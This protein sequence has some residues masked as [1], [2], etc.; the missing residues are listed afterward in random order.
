[1]NDFRALLLTETD[2]K[3]AAAIETLSEDRLPEGDVLID[4]SHSSLNYKDGMIINGLG[5][6]VRKYP[7]VPGVDFTGTVAKSEHPDFKPGDKV[8]LTGWRVGEIHWGGFAEK[9]RVKGDWLVPLPEGLS[10]QRAMAIGTAGLTAMLAVLALEEH[11]L[12]PGEAPVLV[13]GAA[14]GLGSVAV[15]VLAKLGYPVAAVTGRAEQEGY[16]RELGAT[17]IVSRETMATPSGKPLDPERWAGA[18]DAVG[19]A[20]LGNLVGQLRYGASVACC[21]NAGG[22]A[23]NSNVLPL[24][25][26]GVN[27]LGINSVMCPI[28]RR[29][30]AWER[31]SQDLPMAHLDALTQVVGLEDLPEMANKILK[32]EVRG[33]AVIDVRK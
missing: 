28:A 9:A 5:R 15:A 1:M 6:L 11:G 12:T 19:G 7:H 29:K 22:I 23:F 21:G 13:T 10:P 33:R 14:G 3:V 27:V 32:G 31:I 16:L 8:I 4:V 17:E 26:R 25:L 20:I 30:Q 2:G 18:V 24:L